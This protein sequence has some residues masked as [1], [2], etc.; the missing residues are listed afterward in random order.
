MANPKTRLDVL[1]A[2]RGLTDSREAAKRLILAGGARVDG[3]RITK[4]GAQVAA[5]AEIEIVATKPRYASRGGF[6][7]ERALHEFAVDPRDKVALDAG[8]STGGFTDCLLQHGASLVH[9]VDVG[10]GQIAWN[11][12]NDPRVQ[13]Y[14]RTNIRYA[15][16]DM[17]DPPPDMMTADLSFIGLTL[18]MPA[19]AS[20][21]P[22]GGDLVA[23]VKP[24]FEAGRAQ[25]GKGG[26]V[27]DADVHQEVLRKVAARGRDVAMG[28]T[29]V[30][31]SPL[32]GPAGNI[33]FLMRFVR[34]GDTPTDALEAAIPDVVREAHATI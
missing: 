20:L 8:A 6:K 10:Y 14:E 28:P 21:L 23:L 12:R 9:A 31:Y 1:L 27:R 32:R 13:L 22:S 25:V 30:T 16:P 34:D 18:L 4:A 2:E 3:E 24:Q 33:E 19:F 17:F 15:T 5:D 7:L 29:H 26:V 11:L